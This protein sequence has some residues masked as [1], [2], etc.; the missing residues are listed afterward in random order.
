LIATIGDKVKAPFGVALDGRG[1]LYVADPSGYGT[2]N[3]PSIAQYN[4]ADGRFVQ[5]TTVTQKT[6]AIMTPG[7]GAD[8]LGNIYTHLDGCTT[9]TGGPPH[10]VD[11]LYAYPPG[12]TTPSHVYQFAEGHLFS[13]MAFDR[14]ANVYLALCGGTVKAGCEVRISAPGKSLRTIV[15][16]PGRTIGTMAIAP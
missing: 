13:S 4:A 11:V 2:P 14:A 8:S 7:L 6:G 16:A 5:M 3:Y 10:C 15:R 1:T 9:T 12:T